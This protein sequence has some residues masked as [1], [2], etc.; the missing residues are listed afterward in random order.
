MIVARSEV[1]PVAQAS[2]GEV[3]LNLN[4]GS[5]DVFIGLFIGAALP[6]LFAALTIDAV[7]PAG[8]GAG[9]DAARRDVRRLPDL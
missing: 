9:Q 2:G 8:R 5:V 6:F 7:G 4:V 1:E 3:I